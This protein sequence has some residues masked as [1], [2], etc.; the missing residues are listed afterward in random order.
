MSDVFV[1]HEI[2]K[3]LIFAFPRI[4]TESSHHSIYL[5]IMISK[6]RISFEI[7][8]WS[9]ILM[10]EFLYKMEEKQ[11]KCSLNCPED[12]LRMLKYFIGWPCSASL[13]S[14]CY[15]KKLK[16]IFFVKESAPLCQHTSIVPFD[17]DY[18]VILIHFSTHAAR[19]ELYCPD[20]RIEGDCDLSASYKSRS[21][22]QIMAH[23]AI[24]SLNT[25]ELLFFDSNS[26]WSIR[27]SCLRS[28]CSSN[29]QDSL[30]LWSTH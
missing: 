4:L 20:N 21:L 22:I 9:K 23:S 24:A 10:L 28:Y 26:L 15:E 17:N 30:R 18:R 27:A 6:K 8:K 13:T 29:F 3:P 7:E 12:W 25:F 5:F 16:S 14:H 2:P 19:D 1:D 11:L